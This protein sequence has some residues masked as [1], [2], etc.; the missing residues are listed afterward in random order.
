MFSKRR[1]KLSFDVAAFCQNLLEGQV[2]RWEDFSLII[3]DEAHHCDKKHPFNVLLYKHHL[4]LYGVKRRPK[5][6]GLTASPAGKDTVPATIAMLE[7]LVAN[8]GGVSMNIVQKY[9]QT[10]SEFQSNAQI[11]IRPQPDQFNEIVAMFIT[12]LQIYLVYC[13]L[14]LV[15]ISDIQNYV[16]WKNFV[17]LSSDAETVRKCAKNCIEANL[18]TFQICLM[19]IQCKDVKDKYKVRNLL[20]H[21]KSMCM[22]LNSL[23]EGGVPCAVEEISEME[24]EEY[25]FEFA[26]TF[27]L[28]YGKLQAIYDNTRET[29]ETGRTGEQQFG[30]HISRLIE[31]LTNSLDIDW[32]CRETVKPM[33]LV[34]VKERATVHQITR[35]LQVY[36]H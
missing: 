14:R 16:N 34:L 21:T 20:E 17:T 32:S 9:K 3:F 24:K 36:T 8:M 15:P 28:P 29:L 5:I 27:H 4:P 6:L 19:N 25:N 26:K 7:K 12:E 11:I 18:E 2:I 35:I 13:Y 22:A 33:A 31:E 1:V 10:L 23:L 30:S